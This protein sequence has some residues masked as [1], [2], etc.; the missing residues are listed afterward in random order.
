MIW[1]LF[2]IK[3]IENIW[4]EV[5]NLLNKEKCSEGFWPSRFSNSE[6]PGGRMRPKIFNT[7]NEKCLAVQAPLSCRWQRCCSNS[8]PTARTTD[9]PPKISAKI[10]KF[11]CLDHE[12]LSVVKDIF[13]WLLFHV[14]PPTLCQR[15]NISGA[16]IPNFAHT[17]LQSASLSDI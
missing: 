10:M 11:I 2:S 4:L 9:T 3:K 6:N 14:D 16:V 15:L 1:S 8:N 12:L 5:Q 17:C 13:R 7:A